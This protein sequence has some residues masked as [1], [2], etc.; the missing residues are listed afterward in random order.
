MEFE[1]Y[2]IQSFIQFGII[3][4][5][6]IDLRSRIIRLENQKLGCDKKCQ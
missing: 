5:I 1:T 6:L 2:L 4:Y 3:S